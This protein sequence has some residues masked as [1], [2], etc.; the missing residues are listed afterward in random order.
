MTDFSAAWIRV[1]RQLMLGLVLAWLGH[2][3]AQNATVST[4]QIRAELVAHAPNG[5]QAGQ[6]IWVGLSLQHAPQWHTYWINPGDSG[7]PTQL[8]WDLP[9]GVR[10][11]PVLW[12]LPHQLRAGTLTNYGFEG[13]ALLVVPLHIEKDFKPSAK[14][15][16]DI[17][18]H[19]NWLVCRL[20]CIPQEGDFSLSIPAN[21]STATQTAAFESV[22]AQQP[23]ALVNV[24]AI[25]HPQGAGN[26][27]FLTL[28][29]R[30]LPANL[31]GRRL[32][33]FALEPEILDSASHN[34]PQAS[35]AW[36]GDVWQ[37]QL[38]LSNLRSA[39]PAA[40]TLLLVD[41][42]QGTR[43]GWR[44]G[45]K[46]E[47]AWPDPSQEPLPSASVD[48]TPTD[49]SAADNT[50]FVLALLGACLGGLILNLMPCVLPVLAIK[51]LGFSRQH[52][53]AR[54]QRL[55]G[56]AYTLGVVMSFLALGAALLALRASGEQLGWG[57]QL[58]SPG[59]VA[60][61]AGLFTLIALNLF[62]LF[63]LGQVL[64]SAWLSYQAKHPIT[65]AWVSGVLAVVVAS[66]CTAPFMG[67]SLGLA[68]TLPT[69]Q[70]LGIFM[71]MGL[72]LALPY[73]LLSWLPNLARH[74]PQP[75]AWMVTLRQLLGF[76]MLATV[77]WLVWV[78]SLQ[79]SS[80]A[81][82]LVLLG[83]L[84]LSAWV[85]SL[86]YKSHVARLFQVALLAALFT[87]GTLALRAFEHNTNPTAIGSESTRAWR[88]W[89]QES[90]QQTLSQGQPVFVDF[91]AAWCVTCQI[92]KQ[93][94][95]SDPQ[96]LQAFDAR[97]VQRMRADWTRRDPAITRALS[98]LGRSG[99]PV[100]VLYAPG[101]S[102][103]VLSELLSV[104]KIQQAL[105]TL[106]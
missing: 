5:V 6:A 42:S 28:E 52:A 57:F 73:L 72:G 18:L 64:P 85:W 98:A 105:S 40:L 9:P 35:Q 67:A 76:P 4:P 59:V 19:A 3:G 22:L 69:W 65:N 36:A 95:L 92:N 106:P 58:Q 90:V 27:Q 34:H 61:L 15:T 10:A 12:P 31:Q 104:E 11:E 89:S 47:G 1:G 91:T 55:S 54:E 101:R 48:I 84:T 68:M 56:L 30:G 75:G 100:Y 70:A 99:V 20:E 83:L 87:L 66:P 102:P 39:A 74:M 82:A 33:V 21:S 46:I 38:P 53:H 78:L 77:V 93:T 103:V 45:L 13:N 79:T 49:F 17:Q 14:N 62:G 60:L 96:V 37:A 71:C 25:A 97:H 24:Q 23:Q 50:S 81:S 51:F 2:A 86:R 8:E 94:T 63:E 80:D 7:L 44:V 26:A 16:L 29:I 88:N 41:A 43:Q 32:E